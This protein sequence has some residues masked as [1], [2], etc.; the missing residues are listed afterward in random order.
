MFLQAFPRGWRHMLPVF[1]LVCA[2]A[3]LLPAS[4]HADSPPEPQG[5]NLQAQPLLY[6]LV[7]TT[8]WDISWPQCDNGERPAGPINFAVIGVNG[9]RMYTKN[10]CLGEMYRWAGAGRTVPQVYMNT[11]SPPKTYTN[12]GCKDN[13]AWCKSY[14]YGYDGAADA[15]K[16]ARAQGADPRNWWLDVETGNFWSADTVA[17]S[18]VIGGV[19]EYLQATGHTVGVYSTPRQWG[20]IVGDYKPYLPAWTAGA[21]DLVEAPTRCTDRFAF[22]GGRVAMVQYVSE[23]FD[24]NYICPDGIRPRSVAPGLSTTA[25]K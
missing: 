8:A 24:T 21:A 19:I 11:N 20:I 2:A 1:A 6:P 10:D 3:L 12:A 13:D 22:G 25:S 14:Y 16:Y 15:V 18:R 9:G 5:E 23:H 4:G 17:N 7:G